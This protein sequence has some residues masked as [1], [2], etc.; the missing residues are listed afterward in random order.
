MTCPSCFVQSGG[1]QKTRRQPVK[2]HKRSLARP[3]TK[4]G[5]HAGR[6]P[7]NRDKP[8][9]SGYRRTNDFR[10]AMSSAE[11]FESHYSSK[12]CRQF[13][14][15]LQKRYKY[16]HIDP[17][18]DS[19]TEA[20]EKVYAST[21]IESAKNLL[22]S[23]SK[24]AK[25][26]STSSTKRSNAEKKRTNRK[27]IFITVIGLLMVAAAA[28][29]GTYSGWFAARGAPAAPD[30]PDAPGAPA[31]PQDAPPDAPPDAPISNGNG[32]SLFDEICSW[33]NKKW[34]RS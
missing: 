27:R 9:S 33:V 2:T 16:A 26:S 32:K 20:V 14:Q 30:A 7:S 31:A 25:K 34:K 28:G 12:I 1:A 21:Y 11:S 29:A 10:Q 4:R 18:E 3:S 23:P 13:V 22:P 5:L 19:P 15:D 8:A 17:K 24:R 6:T